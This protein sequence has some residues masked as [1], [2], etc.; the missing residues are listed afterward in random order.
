MNTPQAVDPQRV[1]AAAAA[2]PG[3][4][5]PGDRLARIA[6]RRAF[7]DLKRSFLLALQDTRGTE[8]LHQQVRNA[9]EPLDLWELRAPVF[10]ALAGLDEQRRRQRQMLRRGLDSIFTELGPSSG[11]TSF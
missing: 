6:A 4:G 3:I 5:M 10:A 1:G 7:V 9:E 11:F 2:M 8:W